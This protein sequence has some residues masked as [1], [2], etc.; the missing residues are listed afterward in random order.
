LSGLSVQAINELGRAKVRPLTRLHGL[1]FGID[2][3]SSAFLLSNCIWRDGEIEANFR[4]PFDSLTESHVLE[5][6]RLSPR[7]T[8]AQT[9]LAIA[10]AAKLYP[11]RDEEAV[12]WCRR[13]IEANRNS[14]VGHFFSLPPWRSSAG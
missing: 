11:G 13:A 12:A 1:A 9:W 8:F 3:L 7:D 6:L 14:P 2:R 4:Q 10:G 5:P